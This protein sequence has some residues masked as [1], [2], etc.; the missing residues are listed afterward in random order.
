L[1]TTQTVA[2]GRGGLHI[3]L[4][5]QHPALVGVLLSGAALLALEVLPESRPAF[6][7]ALAGMCALWLAL[8]FAHGRALER[9]HE[10]ALAVVRGEA[11]TA[12]AELVPAFEQCA[13][14]VRLQARASHAELEQ[15]QGLV[16]EAIEKLVTSF[17]G[18]N[19]Q[20][21]SQLELA[22]SI[23]KGHADG[24]ARADGVGF[25]KFVGETSSTLKV[26]VDGVVQN[27]KI[28]MGLV[29]K[30][31]EISE[32]ISEVHGILGEIEGISKRTNLLALNAAIES[33][34]AG[35]AGRG[36]AV[37]ADEVRD[38]SGRTREFSQQI[39]STM[40][41]V[42]DSVQATKNAINEM[43]SQDMTFAL[44]SKR[45]VDRTM[46][47][48]REMNQEMARAARELAEITR[49]VD[50]D[51]NTAVT[52]LQFQ[53]IVK[54]LLG[55]VA[56]RVGA[57]DG[58]TARLDAMATELKRGTSE[59]DRAAFQARCRE[60][61][62]ALDAMRENTRHKPVRQESMASGAVEMF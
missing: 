40:G 5:N 2:R 25:E 7:V 22:L 19:A 56:K 35:E 12:V 15:A 20:T 50:R 47:E 32:R 17:N 49:R 61:G 62:E 30:M 37:V 36:F 8:L 29:E 28:A 1:N 31:D 34:R 4:S 58:I 41:L 9:R 14:G 39:R 57:L 21:R 13:A 48:A 23:T 45:G 10:A 43:A 33:A 55:H 38:L 11:A 54:Q 60:L 16:L 52:T 3:A 6:S 46:Q 42:C 51:V 26:F 44:Q 24:G 59:A 27:S 18:I 53:D